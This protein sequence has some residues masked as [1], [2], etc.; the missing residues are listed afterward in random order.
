[1]HLSLPRASWLSGHRL[2]PILA[3]IWVL[4][5]SSHALAYSTE[6]IVS[7]GCHELMT[8]RALRAAR[9]ELPALSALPS[10]TRDDR[11]LL[12]D[13][14]FDM[15][16]DMGDL[17]AAALLLGNRSNDLL[18]NEPDDLDRLAIVH[19]D[20][21]N[22]APHCLRRPDH[23]G[24]AGIEQAVVEC[25]EYIREQVTLA[26][27]GL[28]EGV[29]DVDNR[30]EAGIFLEFRG[31]VDAPLPLFY[32]RLGKAL[33][34]VQD[35]FSH[36]YRTSDQL[37][38]VTPLNYVEWA[39]DELDEARDG[40]PHKSELDRCKDLDDL[41]RLRM[42][43]VETASA[44]LLRLSVSS[45]PASAL[46]Q[47]FATYVTACDASNG[48]CG[49]GA[50][51]DFSNG[52]C[53]A[54]ESRYEDSRG[55]VCSAPGSTGAGGS[56]LWP[57]CLFG[58]VLLLGRRLR[59]ATA[60]GAAVFGVNLVARAQDAPPELPPTTPPA[61]VPP[62]EPAPAEAQPIPPALPEQP[63][64]TAPP[65]MVDGSDTSAPVVDTTPVSEQKK[66]FPFGAAANFSVALENPALAF[67]LGARLRL[68]GNLIVGVDGEYNPWISFQKDELRSG[69]V[70]VYA[71]GILRLPLSFQRVNL[72]TTLQLG[73][74]R[75]MFDIFGVPEGSI[76]PYF[77]INVLG[78]DIELTEAVYL[79]INPAHI[80]VPV[81][82]TS[83]VPFTYPQYRFTV[84]FQFGA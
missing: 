74:A 41:R 11:A 1:M 61:E 4:A 26:L 9:A 15:D 6:S 20:P 58:I 67:A 66:P 14:P 48:Y 19:G 17:G 46:D 24:Q 52:W 3:C 68:S 16:S 75:Q 83:G 39:E 55:C 7:D 13:L 76:G 49:N 18:D 36:A 73:V 63:P 62:A 40:P 2:L 42:D 50:P 54:P 59:V 8:M 28:T 5:S 12:D 21:V 10:R 65:V 35:S 44:D 37:Q 23:D 33:H 51:C 30:V 22:Q 34:A 45:D 69:T 79:I 31:A 64:P 82:Q 47:F 84:G 25:R 29:P 38:I 27:G 53:G 81:P 78:L 43:V 60:L 71:T 70:N 72:R 32:F 56:R 57:L 80:A 77:G